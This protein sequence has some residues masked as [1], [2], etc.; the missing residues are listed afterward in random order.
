MNN[1]YLTIHDGFQARFCTVENIIMKPQVGLEITNK[2]V[3]EHHT[4]FTVL[5]KLMHANITNY[6]K[7]N[8]CQNAHKN[9]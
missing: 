9:F 4:K 5:F 7:R 6:Q 1:P 3:T 2:S 8:L